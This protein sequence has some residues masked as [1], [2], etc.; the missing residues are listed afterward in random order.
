MF[1]FL[2]NEINEIIFSYGGFRKDLDL[3]IG[4]IHNEDYRAI[5]LSNLYDRKITNYGYEEKYTKYFTDKLKQTVY[6]SGA[7][8]PCNFITGNFLHIQQTNGMTSSVA[9]KLDQMRCIS[10]ISKNSY[11]HHSDSDMEDIV[12]FHETFF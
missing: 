7:I 3:F 11:I 1:S 10:F 9:N 8:I 6:T 5:I 12:S 4:V 2:P